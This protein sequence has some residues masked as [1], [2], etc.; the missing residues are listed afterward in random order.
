[1]KTDAQTLAQ[2]YLEL[3][4]GESFRI[5]IGNFMNEFFLYS[6]SSRGRQRLIDTP[7]MMPVSPTEEQQH[8]AAF[9]AGAAEYLAENYQLQC[10]DWAM[11]DIY[12]LLKPW[13]VTPIEDDKAI[14]L[15]HAPA[16]RERLARQTPEPW[17]RRNVFC[18]H[19]IFTNPH[20]SSKEP[21]N[22]KELL[23]HRQQMLEQMS[24]ENRAAY[25]EEYNARVPKW[26]RISA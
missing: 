13:Y 22:H 6:P 12:T 8:W 9:C 10:P 23:Q 4:Q 16:R 17:R 14:S 18:S 3:C 2:A 5:A 19:R 20:P 25:I 21:G 24:P 7:I 11:Q 1:M 15:F 26:M